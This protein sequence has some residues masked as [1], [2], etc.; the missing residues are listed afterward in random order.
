[1]GVVVLCVRTGFV[2]VRTVSALAWGVALVISL[3]LIG[4]AWRRV[5]WIIPLVAGVVGLSVAM[6]LPTARCSSAMTVEACA[7][8]Q[9][10]AGFSTRAVVFLVVLVCSASWLVSRGWSWAKWSGEARAP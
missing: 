7:W 5:G 6:A 3:V 8:Y 1:M 2:P 10:G 4:L 9:Y